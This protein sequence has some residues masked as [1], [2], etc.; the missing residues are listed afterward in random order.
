MIISNIYD[1]PSLKVC[2]ATCF[3]W[4]T[5]AA[6]HL[7]HT[8]KLRWWNTVTARADLNP[9]AALHE[10]GLLPLV[11]KVHFP[12]DMYQSP[13]VVPE[14]FDSESFRYFSVLSNV[15][16]LIITNLDL[17]KFTSSIGNYFGHFS[18]TLR[19][20]TLLFLRGC[21]RQLLDLLRLFPKLD[22]IKIVRYSGTIETHNS[23]DTKS[24]QIRGSLQGRLTLNGFWDQ[25]LLE[26]VI[27]S[28]G[29]MRFISMDL[30]DVVPGAQLLL[31][32]CAGTLQT[33]CFHPESLFHSCKMFLEEAV[34]P[35]ELT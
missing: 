16:D 29:G 4:Y 11:K 31:D 10:L 34:T 1:T 28:L 35:P 19:S 8:L 6:P 3:V 26:E 27:A 21:P 24:A 12:S 25:K 20:I 33:L 22:D 15:Q 7:H 5:I 13:W 9:L 17:S 18:P 23:L 14:T 32:A 30:D 2:A